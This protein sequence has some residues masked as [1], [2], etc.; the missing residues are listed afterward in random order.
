[1]PKK[2][3][4][5]GPSEASESELRLRELT[6]QSLDLLD[7][8]A[9]ARNELQ[10]S[11][12][13][14]QSVSA[15]LGKT[16]Q[17]VEQ[18]ELAQ[19]QLQRVVE[20]ARRQVRV[21]RSLRSVGRVPNEPDPAAV[22]VVFWVPGAKTVD[23]EWLAGAVAD[24]TSTYGVPC[25]LIC[26]GHQAPKP[27][28]RIDQL[29]VISADHA[30][31]AHAFN[32]AMASTDAPAVMIVACGAT[33]SETA[34]AEL[35]GLHDESVGLGVPRISQAGAGASQGLVESQELEMDRCYV[36]AW[37]EASG[38]CDFAAPEAFLVCRA[39]FE[40]VGT[41]DEDLAGPVAL[42]DYALRL[43]QANFRL[44][45]LPGCEVELSAELDLLPDICSDF[46]RMIVTA[47][48]RHADLATML[49]ACPSVAE[50]PATAFLSLIDALFTHLPAD[51]EIG[52]A[53]YVQQLRSLMDREA[54]YVFGA[55]DALPNVSAALSRLH[56]QPCR[57]L[58]QR[59]DEIDSIL[60]RDGGD[61]VEADELLD[62]ILTRI[63]LEI[64]VKG[65]VVEAVASLNQACEVLSGEVRQRD[66]QISELDRRLQGAAD[67]IADRDA[68][69]ADRDAKIAD[70]EAR[71]ADRDARIADLEAQLEDREAQLKEFYSRV[72]DRD[73]QLESAGLDASQLRAEVAALSGQLESMGERIQ[74][75][76]K[77]RASLVEIVEAGA[78]E[79]DSEVSVDEETSF[80]ELAGFVRV[81]SKTLEDRQR[82]IVGLLDELCSK[83]LRI[84][85]RKLAPHEQDFIAAFRKTSGSTDE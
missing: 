11:R 68:K 13:E 36:S 85:A 60:S 35:D 15:E 48:H 76:A 74:E 8:L 57:G 62:S 26:Q 72:A 31:P 61:D 47:R 83:R 37:D 42:T 29:V 81:I 39:A 51:T 5:P 25:S 17:H 67:Q 18:L 30:S 69:I 4:K 45:A 46:D 59:L 73:K 70:H 16:R 84:K 22:E 38:S 77:G 54:H 9:V 6:D 80:E 19:R 65:A 1:M 66:E 7:Q 78:R 71:V 82:W 27:E 21:S 40:E 20:D 2:K 32:L 41:F 52:T 44:H 14:T 3:V 75:L 64:E 49:A 43:Q 23:A 33:L 12:D 56:A 55:D 79:V 53:F 28:D 58:S 34:L 10:E 63:H 50:L 24:V